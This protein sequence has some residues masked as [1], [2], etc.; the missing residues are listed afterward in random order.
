M[1]AKSAFAVLHVVAKNLEMIPV[2]KPLFAIRTVSGIILVARHVSYSH[3]LKAHIRSYPV[4]FIKRSN[5][6]GV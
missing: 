5:R 4:G 3:I 6:C 2:D 1:S